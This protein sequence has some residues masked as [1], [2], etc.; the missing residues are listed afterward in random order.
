KAGDLSWYR[1]FAHEEVSTGDTKKPELGDLPNCKVFNET[2]TATMHTALGEPDKNAMLSFRSSSYGSTSHALANQNA[3][4]TF[5]GGKEIFYSSGHRTGFTDDHGMYAYRNTRAHNTILVNGM[6]QKM[7]TEGY[8]WIPRWYEG[9]Q[10]SYVVGDASNAYG[11]VSAPLW[12]ER[13]RLSGTKFTPENGWDKNKLKCFRRHI[14]QLGT[15]G[16][17]VIYDEL[18]GTEPV[19]WSYLLHTTSQPMEVNTLAPDAVVVTGHNNIGGTSVAH[20]FASEKM[21]TAVVDTFF[22]APTNWK[23]VTN[24][25]GQSVKYA[26][27]WHFNATTPKAQTARFLSIIDTHGNDRQGWEVT[28][29]GNTLQVAGWTIECNLGA[30]GSA[31]I[32]VSNKA[33]GA[34][35]YY[36][37]AKNGGATLVKDKVEGKS[38]KQKLVDYLPD[39]E[40]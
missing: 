33:E 9:K 27:H 25:K 6:T 3:F 4:N 1:C 20:L 11:E 31:M 34:S 19:T 35:L 36:N 13:A 37:E 22:S 21:Q 30:T 17:Y 2:G 14:I 12:L 8:G 24:A 7:G 28:R 18:E 23:N 32:R 40:I 26:N 10:L 16:V 29:E 39:F 5:Y 38:V 15:T